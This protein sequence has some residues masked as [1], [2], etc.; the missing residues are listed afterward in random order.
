MIGNADRHIV[1]DYDRTLAG[2][3]QLEKILWRMLI[4]TTDAVASNLRDGFGLLCW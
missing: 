3:H 4:H 2:N 1:S